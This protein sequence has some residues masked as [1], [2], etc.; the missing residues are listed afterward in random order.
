MKIENERIMQL[1]LSR[2]NTQYAP[3]KL[4]EGSQIKLIG[5][6]ENEN[7]IPEK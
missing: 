4:G 1:Q 5:Q 2:Q 6:M 3:K 7:C